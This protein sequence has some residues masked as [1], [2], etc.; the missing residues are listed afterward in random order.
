MTTHANPCGDVTVGW[1]ITWLVTCFHFHSIPFLL[2]SLDCTKETFR[3]S[4]PGVSQEHISL[5]NNSF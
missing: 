3:L 1:A 5:T 4:N 2:C